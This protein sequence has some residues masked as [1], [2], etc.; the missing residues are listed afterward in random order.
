VG[1]GAWIV[2]LPDSA[3][4]GLP[5]L[6]LNDVVRHPPGELCIAR[7]ALMAPIGL[8]VRYTL[9]GHFITPTISAGGQGLIRPSWFWHQRSGTS[10]P[11]PV[12]SRWCSGP[13]YG[14]F[15]GLFLL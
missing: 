7:G 6:R 8:L 5:A 12:F 13:G 3:G 15:S 4:F 2:G 10:V 9:E 14:N 1:I 11:A